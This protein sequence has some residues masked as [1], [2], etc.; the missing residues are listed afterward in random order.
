MAQIVP[1]K[2]T[3]TDHLVYVLQKNP[4][5]FD[6]IDFGRIEILIKN[7]RIVKIDATQ[8]FLPEGDEGN[9]R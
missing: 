3:I 2:P 9:L 1:K 8:T 5:E 4:K 6:S 7:S